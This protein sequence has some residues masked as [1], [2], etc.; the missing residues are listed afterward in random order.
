MGLSGDLGNV[1]VVQQ[2]GG[3]AQWKANEAGG[4]LVFDFL[5]PVEEVLKVGLMNVVGEAWIQATDADGA[6]RTFV[7]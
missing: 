3:N 1:L 7:V 2:T 5:S 6:T 4:T